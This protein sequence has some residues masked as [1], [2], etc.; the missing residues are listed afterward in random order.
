[1]NRVLDYG[2]LACGTLLSGRYWPLLV[3]NLLPATSTLNT[4]S[5]FSE[6]SIIID[7]CVLSSVLFRCFQITRES[8]TLKIFFGMI[9]FN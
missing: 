7:S 3:S 4:R 1:M 8:S 6:S 5:C 2:V 9:K